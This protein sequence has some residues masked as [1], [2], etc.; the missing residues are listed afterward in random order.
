MIRIAGGE[1]VDIP[2]NEDHDLQLIDTGKVRN[3]TLREVTEA[4]RYLFSPT[5]VFS[6]VVFLGIV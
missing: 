4:S 6:V 3:E 2:M 5:D 1:F